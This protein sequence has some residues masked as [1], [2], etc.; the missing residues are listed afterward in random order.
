MKLLIVCSEYFNSSNG[1]CIST[2][3]FVHEFRKLGDEVRILA[4]DNGGT[5]DYR[6]SAMK[7]PFIEDVMDKQNFH[8]AEPDFKVVKEAI[9]WADLIHIEDPFPL[10]VVA[11]KMAQRMGVPVTGTFHLYP[12]NMTASVPIFD[13]NLSNRNIMR[14]FR[15]HTY[16]YCAAIQC[17]TEKVKRRLEECG[18]K[19]QLFVISNGI[20]A[21]YIADEPS[22]EHNEIFTVI[23]TGRYSNE[24]DQITLLNAIKKSKYGDQIQVILAGQGPKETEY[25]K[26][27]DSLPI[28]PIMKFYSLEELRKEVRKAD[29][30]V[31]C[32]NVEIEGMACMEAFAAGTVPV[33]A[34]S[35]LSSTSVYALTEQNIYDAGDSDDLAAKI[36]YWF[37]NR[38]QL[39]EMSRRY[40]SLAKTLS[41]EESAGKV[42]EM[43][44][45]V[46]KASRK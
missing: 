26:I 19:S 2:Q 39:S 42:H 44:L 33:I 4:S 24:K 18:F 46:L 12:E 43:M 22:T 6:V 7:L 10:C 27:G 34:D 11:A 20:P 41:I 38:D 30:Y 16:Q 17:P 9:E 40:I 5:P 15:M 28:P 3:R 36:D 31:H 25:R 35:K 8:F 29:L 37:E 23:C 21:E 1:L 45:S 14:V 13:F 32:A